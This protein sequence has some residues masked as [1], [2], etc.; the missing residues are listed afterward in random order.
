MPL[1]LTLYVVSLLPFLCTFPKSAD[2][3]WVLLRPLKAYLGFSVPEKCPHLALWSVWAVC[4]SW[5]HAES[6]VPFCLSWPYCLF[7]GRNH[8]CAFFGPHLRAGV[9][10]SAPPA[11]KS[12]KRN[13]PRLQPQAP[14]RSQSQKPQT[15]QMLLCPGLICAA[16]TGS[17]D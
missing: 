1:K 11:G 4:F 12:S 14:S 17:P 15:K 13:L 16:S 6:L 7:L 5:N 9:R 2:H 8:S 3:S 10:S